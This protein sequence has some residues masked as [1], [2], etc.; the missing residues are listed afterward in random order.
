[1]RFREIE[2]TVFQLPGERERPDAIEVHVRPRQDHRQLRLCLNNC[3]DGCRPRSADL[4]R[5]LGYANE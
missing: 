1:M 5:F 3:A 4:E 2:V